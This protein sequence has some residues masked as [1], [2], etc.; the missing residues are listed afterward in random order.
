MALRTTEAWL[1]PRSGQP[2]V[3][4]GQLPV[5]VWSIPQP[6]GAAAAWDKRAKG[7]QVVETLLPVSALCPPNP[8][9]R[10]VSSGFDWAATGFGRFGVGT[11][12]IGPNVGGKRG[13]VVLIEFLAVRMIVGRPYPLSQASLAQMVADQQQ[14]GQKVPLIPKG[15]NSIYI[16]PNAGTAHTNRLR[17][18]HCSCV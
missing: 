12:D 11:V 18:W 9:H 1:R 8:L 13:G 15:Y 4:P 17:V 6:K 16:Q 14:T 5:G 10:I 2:L 3:S 7:L